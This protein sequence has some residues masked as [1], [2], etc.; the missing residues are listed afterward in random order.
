MVDVLDREAKTGSAQ[1]G[2]PAT[3]STQVHPQGGVELLESFKDRLFTQVMLDQA[4]A[5]ERASQQVQ[6]ILDLVRRLGVLKIESNYGERDF[7]YDFRLKLAAE[8]QPRR[9]MN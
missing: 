9:D 6:T 1:K 5:P 2:S 7:R 3:V 4:L 8:N